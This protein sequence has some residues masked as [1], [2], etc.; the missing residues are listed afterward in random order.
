VERIPDRANQCSADRPDLPTLAR[1]LPVYRRRHRPNP[2]LRRRH[3]TKPHRRIL[4]KHTFP[5]WKQDRTSRTRP[6]RRCRIPALAGARRERIRKPSTDCDRLLGPDV[7]GGALPT[8]R[9]DG[10][11][12][13]RLPNQ[14]NPE[15][16][17]SNGERRRIGVSAASS[18]RADGVDPRT[19]GTV[20]EYLF[21][22]HSAS[23]AD[24]V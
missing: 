1:S 19:A 22:Q 18:S 20:E 15:S 23:Y 10:R 21:T 14:R 2:R 13:S 7:Q 24:I 9:C 17:D 4:R 8:R 3:G 16:H 11:L 6:A 12:V 5:L